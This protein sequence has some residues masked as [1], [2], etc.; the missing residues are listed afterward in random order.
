MPSVVSGFNVLPIQYTKQST[1]YLYVRAHVPSK[2]AGSSQTLPPN[3]TLFLVNV[4]PDASERE[5]IIFF[6]SCGTVERV[7]FDMD[8]INEP[9][10]DIESDEEDEEQ[11]EAPMDVEQDH[12][13]KK[14]KVGKDTTKAPT[15]TPLPSNPI[16]IL[17]KTGRSAHLIFLDEVSLPKALS[18]GSKPRPWPK[19]QDADSAPSGLAHYMQLYSSLRP[20]LDVVRAHAD[21]SIDLY[22]YELAKSRQN[23]KYK[24]GEAIVDDDGFTLVTRGGAY[25]KTLGG[26]VGVAS[27]QFTATAGRGGG[28][29]MRKQKKES[30]EKEGFYAFQKAEKQRKELMDLKQ[31]WEEDKVK[32]EKLK[33]SRR[34]KPY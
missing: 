22:E 24:K 29:R 25:G 6:R 26:G 31:R 16:R 4:P 17:R 7:I 1:H 2:K 15:V 19:V 18:S 27:K 23:S 12:P 28:G 3:R 20:P 30:K 5:L 34:F 33:A 9:G 13:R 21:S 10:N 32:V 14:R 8:E 11:E